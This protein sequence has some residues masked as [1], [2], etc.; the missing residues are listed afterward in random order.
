MKKS[1]IIIFLMLS[2][3]FS[4]NVCYANENIDVLL[5]KGLKIT[6]N[7]EIQ[8]F[9]NVNGV[10]VYPI[11]YQGT[12]YLPIRSISS[13]FKAEIKWDE[14]TNSIYLGEGK[15]DTISSN[16]IE[17]FTAEPNENIEVILNQEITIYY[18]GKIQKFAD[19]KNNTVYPLSHNGTTYLPVRAVSN[20][21]NLKINWD[22]EKNLVSIVNNIE[23]DA[24]KTK[25]NKTI[26]ETENYS[27][28]FEETNEYLQKEFKEYGYDKYNKFEDFAK[29]YYYTDYI[30]NIESEIS[31][32]IDNLSKQLKERGI[33]YNSYAQLI[34]MIVNNLTIEEAI[35]MKV[36]DY[37]IPVDTNN[38]SKI[39]ED[40]LLSFTE[41]SND[42]SKKYPNLIECSKPVLKRYQNTIV[43]Y[44]ISKDLIATT[45]Y[46]ESLKMYDEEEKLYITSNGMVF[47]LPGYSIKIDKNL[48][49]YQMGKHATYYVG[50]VSSDS[51]EYKYRTWKK[52][53]STSELS[54]FTPKK[55]DGANHLML[56]GYSF[57]EYGCLMLDKTQTITT[58]GEWLNDGIYIAIRTIDES[59]PAYYCIVTKNSNNNFDIYY[60]ISDSEIYECKDVPLIYDFYETNSLNDDGTLKMSNEKAGIV[61]WKNGDM[62]FKVFLN[63]DGLVLYQKDLYNN[64]KN[65]Y[66]F[67][68]FEDINTNKFKIDNF[69]RSHYKNKK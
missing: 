64:N 42:S 52:A 40:L 8:E 16:K 26:F 47:S 35:E 58:P 55:N 3:L 32:K 12:T 13:L 39:S 46:D 62:L 34:Y 30:S 50:S 43:A 69:L 2:I 18:N 14:T 36:F 66:E 56:T 21:F 10:K 45:E 11:S 4:L 1:S 33:Y 65:E 27:E 44:E 24:A 20:L 38:K 48:V 60:T 67:I 53:F 6:F 9:K 28:F 17:E 63:N 49:K 59:E 31:I 61:T 68:R 54:Y 7:D 23:K 25:Q 57:F 29:Y 37:V 22:G 51:E 41:L 5:N 15:S 19:V